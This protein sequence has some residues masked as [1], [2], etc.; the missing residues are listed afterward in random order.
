MPHTKSCGTTCHTPRDLCRV[1]RGKHGPSS[2]PA[3][4]PACMHAYHLLPTPVHAPYM[5]CVN[6]LRK[7][8]HASAPSTS[9]SLNRRPAQRPAPWACVCWRKQHCLCPPAPRTRVHALAHMRCVPGLESSAHFLRMRVL[10][11]VHCPNARIG[12]PALLRTQTFTHKHTHKHTNTQKIHKHTSTHMHTSTHPPTQAQAH[13]QAYALTQAR[14]QPRPHLRTL[15]PF[16]APLPLL[17]CSGPWRRRG[18]GRCGSLR[19]AAACPSSA[20]YALM[21]ACA[22]V[23]LT[24]CMCLC[25]F[26]CVHVFVCYACVRT[27]CAR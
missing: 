12:S 9:T 3:C 20:V 16:G 11:H 19:R 5:N 25:V 6:S 10:A 13:K 22:C 7:P 4:L 15:M 17:A 26:D 1:G 8:S 18:R 21:C 27:C 24:V 2:L 23:C 14:M